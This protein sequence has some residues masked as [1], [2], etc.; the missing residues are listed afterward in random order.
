MKKLFLL[1]SVFFVMVHGAYCQSLMERFQKAEQ[2]LPKNTSKLVINAAIR[3][4]EVENSTHEVWLPEGGKCCVDSYLRVNILG[5]HV[6]KP[7]SSLHLAGE[8]IKHNKEIKLLIIPNRSHGLSDHPY[9]IRKRWD[10]FVKHLL[11]KKPPKEYETRMV[12][13]Y[14]QGND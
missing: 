1:S 6:V 4:V 9:F 10:W 7:A 13:S 12:N 8:L 5:E 14:T 2:Y 11:K 3:P